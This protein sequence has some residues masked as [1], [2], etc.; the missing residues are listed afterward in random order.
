MPDKGS[1]IFV[2]AGVVACAP[3]VPLQVHDDQYEACGR[4]AGALSADAKAIIGKI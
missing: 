4:R 3:S 1:L 2:L